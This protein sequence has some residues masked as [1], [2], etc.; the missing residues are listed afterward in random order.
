ME[1]TFSF[2][3][4]TLVVHLIGE[5]DEHAA[6]YA[7]RA[8]DNAIEGKSFSAVIFDLSRLAFMYSTGIGVLIGRYKLLRSKH[9]PVYVKNPSP[10]INKIFTMAGLYEIMPIA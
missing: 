2:Q 8:I 7:R 5:L 4:K 10:T 6:E 3:A 1:V 9:C